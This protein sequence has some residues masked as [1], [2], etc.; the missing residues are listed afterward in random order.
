YAKTVLTAL[1]AIR[2]GVIAKVV[3]AGPQRRPV[4][5][6]VGPY[7]ELHALGRGTT[8]EAIAPAIAV[9]VQQFRHGQLAIPTGLN[10]ADTQLPLGVGIDLVERQPTP[11]IDVPAILEQRRTRLGVQRTAGNPGSHH[12]L[13]LA[14]HYDR[15]PCA[16]A[17]T[18]ILQGKTVPMQP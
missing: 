6:L 11:Q 7:R 15:N 16:D 9:G 3:V 12:L 13:C 8:A 14:Q 4:P 2:L 17:R 1:R 5:G 18:S 10:D